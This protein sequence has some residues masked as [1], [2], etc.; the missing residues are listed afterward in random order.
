[1]L[2]P[3]LMDLLENAELMEQPLVWRIYR[4]LTKEPRILTQPRDLKA[5]SLVLQ[6]G[7]NPHSSRH[8]TQVRRALRVL[9]EQGFVVEHGRGANNMRRVTLAFDRLAQN[10]APQ[11][12]SDATAAG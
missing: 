10:R 7:R 3:A 6:V 12:G 4:Q 11:T 2:F 8:R 5:A 1:M 9:I